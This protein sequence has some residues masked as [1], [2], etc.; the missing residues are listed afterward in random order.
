[1][2]R[3]MTALVTMSRGELDRAGVVARVAE[4]RLTQAHAAELL[5]LSVRQVRRLCRIH[6][7]EGPSG[8]ASKRRGRPSNRLL[9][10]AVRESALELVRARYSDF[11]P[12]LAHEKLVEQHGFGVSLTTVRRWMVEAELWTPRKLRDRRV[13]Q[14]RRRRECLGELIQIDGCEHPW[15]EERAAKCV[16]LVFVD[17]ATGRLMELRFASTESTFSYFTS[18]RRY[19][20][21]HGRPVA[22]YSDK[23]TI[24]RV[25]RNSHQGSGLTQFGRAMSELNIDVLCANSAP[26][27]GRVERAHLTLQDRLVKELRLAG[28]CSMA[29]GNALLPGFVEDYNRRFGREPQSPH[30]AHRPLPA[31]EPL[32]DIFQLQVERKVSRNL[33]VQYRRVLYLLEPTAEAHAVKGQRVRIYEDDDGNVSIRAG[34]QELPARPFAKEPQASIT[35]GD[36][37]DNKLLGTV[38]GEIRNHQLAREQ[39]RLNAARTKRERRLLRDRIQA[40]GSPAPATQQPPTG[41]F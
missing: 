16:L 39:E 34:D 33:T 15:F 7:I 9:P 31:D 6:E 1:M 19:L 38:L 23:A 8:F 5:G 25:N 2:A 37:V 3:A 32:E 13:H 12:T 29:D 30:D 22:F 35:P 14:P 17:D 20:E 24:F 40:A 10:G 28:A 11:G 18:V 26:A 4:G 21:R 27:K 36:I 41:H